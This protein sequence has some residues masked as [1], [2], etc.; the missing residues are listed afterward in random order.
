MKK[1]LLCGF[2]GLGATAFAASNTFKVDLLQKSVIDG[3]TLNTGTY[4]ISVKDGNAVLKRGKEEIQ[5]PAREQIET[6]KIASTE[7]FYTNGSN[8]QQIRIGG[9]HT[10][11]VFGGASAMHSGM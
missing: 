9:T 4:K 2:L 3:K 1:L 5:V 8:L 7:L 10:A 11:I 6:Q